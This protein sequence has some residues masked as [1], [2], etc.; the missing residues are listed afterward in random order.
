LVC[1]SNPSSTRSEQ[2]S[3]FGKREPRG[4]R[5]VLSSPAVAMRWPSGENT[6]LRTMPVWPC[7]VAS[8]W[9]SSSKNFCSCATLQELAM[10]QIG[11]KLNLHTGRPVIASFGWWV[12]HEQ[13][14][15]PFCGISLLAHWTGD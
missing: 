9:S 15:D 7:R 1:G 5:A 8:S 12:P 10:T 11:G 6:A 14:N 2:L 3:N 4:I 13:I